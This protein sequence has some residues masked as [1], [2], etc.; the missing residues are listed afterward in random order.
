MN[1]KENDW[2]EANGMNQVVDGDK[3]I[4]NKRNDL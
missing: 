2:D 4:H 1:Q 3:M